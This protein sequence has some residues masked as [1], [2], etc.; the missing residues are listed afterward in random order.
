M[1]LITGV[2]IRGFRSIQNQSLDGVG[3]LTA[4]VGRNSSG[5]SNALRALNLFFNDEIEPGQS[6]VLERDFHYRPQ[7]RRKKEV[8]IAVDFQLPAN[9]KFRKS[10]NALKAGLGQS[11]TIRR[12][13]SWDTRR[14]LI[15]ATELLQAGKKPPGGNEWARQ[16]LQLIAFRYIPNR[17][18]PSALLRDESREIASSIFAKMQGVAGANTLLASM[19]TAADVLLKRAAESMD[20]T[21]SP[22]ASPGLASPDSLA[23]LLSVSGFQ[24][25]GVLGNMVR[26]EQWGAGTQAFFLYEVLQAID[27]NYSRSFGWKQAAIWGV[28][29]PESGLHRDLETR[30]A[31]E[32]RT[33]T[34]DNK[35]KLQII[36][37]THSPIFTM[38]SDAGYWVE[39]SNAGTTWLKAPIPSLVRDA[40]LRGVSGWVQPILAF[41]TNPVILVEGPSDA[42]VLSH[43]AAALGLDRLR[44]LALPDLD[45]AE[46]GGGKDGLTTYL[47]KHGGLLNNRPKECPLLVLFDWD[48]SVDE[49]ERA[50]KAYGPA[51]PFAVL[52]MDT[53]HAAFEMG[54]DFRGIERF[55]PPELVREASDAGEFLVA[56]KEGKPM[57][58]SSMQLGIAKQQLRRRV[59]GLPKPES[60][61]SLSAVVQEIDAAVTS[62]VSRQLT[63]PMAQ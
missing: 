30:L 1:R 25:K 41:P 44:F 10:L 28:E 14:N 2:S 34:S 5:K 43:V 62:F 46:R 42:E 49:I 50:K 60:M 3:A 17:T 13:W 36:Q 31:D 37:T 15:T 59:M 57:S 55:Y 27:T 22:I 23:D 26:D 63:L 53:K 18:V 40:E 12:S 39:I 54:A 20:R 48:V 11:F 51:G 8:E 19:R 45:P 4:L 47:K 38:A 6:L 9:F 35:L 16:F 32:F 56:T 58:I 61:K 33:W 24:G 29:E 21:G 7:A 52:K